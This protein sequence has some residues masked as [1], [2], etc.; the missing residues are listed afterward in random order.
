MKAKLPQD[1]IPEDAS[2]VGDILD[3]QMP[4]IHPDG[5]RELYVPAFSQGRRDNFAVENTGG[6]P[7]RHG[8]GIVVHDDGWRLGLWLQYLL[9][10]VKCHEDQ[11]H[12]VAVA[13]IHQSA[14]GK[15]HTI[16]RDDP[17]LLDGLAGENFQLVVDVTRIQYANFHHCSEDTHATN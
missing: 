3:H 1:V 6:V 13:A 12:D 11:P 14:P 16:V 8:L 5:F 17:L 15:F 4:E 10:S 9:E 7:P 2:G